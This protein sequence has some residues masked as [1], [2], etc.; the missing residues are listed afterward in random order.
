MVDGERI[1]ADD[2]AEKLG[3]EEIPLSQRTYR[4][5]LW[6]PRNQVIWYW[7]ITVINSYTDVRRITFQ[8]WHFEMVKHRV[9]WIIQVGFGPWSSETILGE[10]VRLVHWIF[11]LQMPD[12]QKVNEVL[13]STCGTVQ[14]IYIDPLSFVGKKMVP[15]PSILKTWYVLKQ[16]D[17]VTCLT[18]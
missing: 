9:C 18:T 8:K 3:L 17:S 7:R 6:H 5:R 16:Y 15:L 4:Y 14:L 10:C 2:T 1:A 12:S 11:G 13:G